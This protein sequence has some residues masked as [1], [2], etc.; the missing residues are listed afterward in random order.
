MGLTLLYDL[1]WR[2]VMC[3]QGQ[4]L[5]PD[6]KTQVLGEATSFG[7]EWLEGKGKEGT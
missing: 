5:T 4:T 3:V 6:S 1:T 2:D 7:D